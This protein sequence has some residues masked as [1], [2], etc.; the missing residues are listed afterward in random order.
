MQTSIPIITG[1]S[2]TGM[3]EVIR[4]QLGSL[5]E[6]RAF[7]SAGLTPEVLATENA[8]IP[9]SAL[10]T[11]ID[12]TA[13][14]AGMANLGLVIAQHLSLTRYGTWGRYLMEAETL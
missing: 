4:S 10:V 2:L 7:G 8:F 9:E 3:P 1:A 13:R 12:S 5:A 11:F 14:Q 6:R